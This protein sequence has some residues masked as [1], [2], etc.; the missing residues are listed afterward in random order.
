M[1]LNEWLTLVGIVASPIAAVLISLWIEGRRRERDGKMAVVRML[2]ATSHMPADPSYSTAIN[3]LRVEFAR[4]TQVMA[5][6]KDY[7][8][9][10]RREQPAT[11]EGAAMLNAEVRAAQLKLL[12]AVLADVG[13]KV[14]EADLAIEG[15]A[16]NGF[17]ARDNLYL[18]SLRAQIRTAE[19]LEK[20]IGQ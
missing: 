19:A 2:I 3:L 10:I 1:G 8:R 4:S 17:I 7:Q 13:M 5:S 16:S 18:E 9:V 14:S 12:S 11:Q 15:Y 6:F 20:S